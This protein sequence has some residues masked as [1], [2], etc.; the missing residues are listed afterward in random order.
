MPWSTSVRSRTVRMFFASRS[1]FWNSPKRLTPN[2]ASRM[3]KSD[4][5]SPSAS[6]ERA[7]GQSSPSKLVRFTIM[8]STFR[9]QPAVDHGLVWLHYKTR[10]P[11]YAMRFDNAT[12]GGGCETEEQDGV[13][14]GRQ[15]RHRARHRPR[16][17]GGRREGRD[18]R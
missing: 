11:S 4:H 15:Q 18:H 3:I 12:T 14:H 2:S 5:Q 1:F 16:I 8:A 6:S 17:R 13:D 9:R 10:Y 7:I